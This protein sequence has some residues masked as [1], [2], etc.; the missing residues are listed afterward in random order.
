MRDKEA[1]RRP[2][3]RRLFLSH[4]GS[5]D[6]VDHGGSGDSGSHG[7]SAFEPAAP[8][9]ASAST[10]GVLLP[11][12]KNSLGKAG[13]LSGWYVGGV[14]SWGCPGSMGFRGSQLSRTLGGARAACTPGGAQALEGAVLERELEGAV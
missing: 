5:G 6:S 9:R 12:Q 3:G 13:A 8:A 4:G 14:G 7:G 10:A 2:P 1:L 11:P